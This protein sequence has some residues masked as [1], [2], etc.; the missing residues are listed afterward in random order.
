MARR[1]LFLLALAFASAATA[2]VV[3]LAAFVLPGG[4]EL[5]GRALETFTG[6]ASPPLKPSIH[7]VAL[8]A[9]PLPFATV[10]AALIAL[11]LLRRRW[12][13]AAVV[14]M[15]LLSANLVTQV[16]KPALA[17]PR[18]VDLRGVATAY[19]GSWPSGHSTA[20]MSL[21]LCLVL[22]AGPRLRALA[23]LAGA[24]YAIAVGYALVA[25]GFHLPSDVLGG[26]LVASTFTLLGAA[27][28]AALEAPRPAR[29][30]RTADA[31]ALL[32]V[33]ALTGFAAGL[34][35]AAGAAVLVRAPSAP[36]D[37]FDHP[38]AV[39][40]GIGIAGLGLAL[41]TGLALVLR[42]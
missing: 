31:P 3:W 14:P 6:V 42:R 27:T 29:S 5:D 28:L 22:V 38:I 41:T 34:L 20:A 15:I 17:D 33:P 39:L 9:E 23:A 2:F 40:A 10:A 19:P 25:L 7:G 21:A 37:A 36:A 12:L 4:R 13:M 16:L 8:L 24:G 35:V 1:P 18:I 26:Y 32:S 11:A 30:A